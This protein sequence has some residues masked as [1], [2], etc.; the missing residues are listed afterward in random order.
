[1]SDKKPASRTT[2]KNSAPRQSQAA[3]PGQNMSETTAVAAPGRSGSSIAPTTAPAGSPATS[4]AAGAATTPSGVGVGTDRGTSGISTSDRE[5]QQTPDVPVMSAANEADDREQ[6]IRRR[7]Y[8]LWEAEGRPDGREQ[9]H[10][11]QAHRELMSMG[12]AGVTGAGTDQDR[13]GVVAA[14]SAMNQPGA[15]DQLDGTPSALRT[16]GR[17]RDGG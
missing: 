4:A 8:E 7:A 5:S 12:G 14:P 15:S 6:R 10:W 17:S 16:A 1:M 11:A 13:A 9:E 3:S 2:S